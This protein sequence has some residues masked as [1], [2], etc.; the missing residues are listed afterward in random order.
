[1]DPAA[2]IRTILVKDHKAMQHFKF[3][4]SEPTGFEKKDFWIV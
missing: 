4:A 3:Q 1:M 2:L